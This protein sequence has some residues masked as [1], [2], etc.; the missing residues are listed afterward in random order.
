[1]KRLSSSGFLPAS[2]GQEAQD[3]EKRA[4]VTESASQTFVATTR[5]L[6][7]NDVGSYSLDS[8]KNLSDTDRLW[9]L[10]NSFRPDSSYKFPLKEEYGKKR[11]FQHSW[12]LQ[13]HGNQSTHK[14][15]V[16]DFIGYMEKGKIPIDQQLQSQMSALV[17]DNRSKLLAILKTIVFC[18]KQ[19]ISLRGHREQS[20]SSSV[21]TN[22]GNFLAL[23]RFRVNAGDS[24]L[25]RHFN[26]AGNAQYT[27]P[28]I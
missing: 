5:P 20:E 24:V 9:L 8:I 1:M 28:Q 12:L 4:R 3:S 7:R 18:G 2:S 11:S 15:A 13:E 19:L 27:S 21:D 23:L 16:I 14:I 6:V 26:T 10:K 17:Q 22:P 25:E